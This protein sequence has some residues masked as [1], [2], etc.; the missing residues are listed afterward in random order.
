MRVRKRPS[1]FA[2]G[3]DCN[4]A[5]GAIY[6]VGRINFLFD[7]AEQPHVT[8]DQLAGHV[9]VVTATMANKAG[10]INKRSTSACTSP[11]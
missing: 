2:R 6:A 7:P 1:P 11:T 9:G 3:D 10:L 4:C 8:T 5:A